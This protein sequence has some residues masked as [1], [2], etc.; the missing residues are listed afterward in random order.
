MKLFIKKLT[1]KDVN[2]QRGVVGKWTIISD[3]GKYYDSFV[4]QWNS[5]WTE[6][7]TL[8]LQ[9]SQIESREYNG[10]TYYSIKPISNSNRQATVAP[11]NPQIEVL[12][13]EILAEIK[14]ANIK[15]DNMS[16]VAGVPTF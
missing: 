8:E 13:K 3:N 9:D 16:A 2:T 11:V 12:L 5:N 4:N 6:G 15:L 10:K 7:S 14:Q 1:K